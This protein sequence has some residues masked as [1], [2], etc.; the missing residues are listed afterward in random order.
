MKEY[1]F[2]N[3]FEIEAEQKQAK[4]LQKM[5]E[6]AK[7]KKLLKEATFTVTTIDD[8]LLVIENCMELIAVKKRNPLVFTDLISSAVVSGVDKI[9][10]DSSDTKMSDKIKKRIMYTLRNSMML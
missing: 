2:K 4:K 10:S 1:K 3:Q 5:K 6:D 9:S 8:A 7:G